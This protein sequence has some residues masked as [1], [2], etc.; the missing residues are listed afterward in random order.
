[1]TGCM[2]IA[3]GSVTNWMSDFGDAA[4]PLSFFVPFMCG[5]ALSVVLLS[6]VGS[7]VDTVIVSFAESPLE[8]ER[9]HPGLYTQMARAWRLAFPEEFR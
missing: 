4:L 5:L 9:N 1:M 7:A 2:G 6:V 8:F 3:L